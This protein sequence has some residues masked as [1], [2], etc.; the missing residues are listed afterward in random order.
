M[1]G[2]AFGCGAE[3]VAF[4]GLVQ[5]GSGLDR[6]ALLEIPADDDGVERLG[7]RDVGAGKQRAVDDDLVEVS[8]GV[9]V[10][11]TN[12]ATDAEG[13]GLDCRGHTTVQAVT[14]GDVADRAVGTFGSEERAAAERSADDHGTQGPGNI[15]VGARNVSTGMNGIDSA[16]GHIKTDD[17]APR[18]HRVDL[19]AEVDNGSVNGSGGYGPEIAG[20]NDSGIIDGAAVAGGQTFWPFN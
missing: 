19:V 1:G 11:G 14:N 2:S 8:T 9:N 13:V 18:C 3:V 20:A 6:R 5:D 12:V 10:G 7:N 17:I 4:D 15:D 16:C